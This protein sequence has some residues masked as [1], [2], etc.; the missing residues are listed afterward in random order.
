MKPTLHAAFIVALLLAGLRVAGT[1]W[2]I[3][4]ALAGLVYLFALMRP[5][6]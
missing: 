6:A 5:T 2:S 4:V 3:P 1:D